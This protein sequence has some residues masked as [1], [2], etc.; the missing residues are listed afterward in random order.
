MKRLESRE[1]DEQAKSR[2]MKLLELDEQAKSREMKLRELEEQAE[3]R[4][5]VGSIAGHILAFAAP[6]ANKMLQSQY[7]G[8]TG[9]G[10]NSPLSSDS[11]L[12]RDRS[13]IPKTKSGIQGSG[14][15]SSKPYLSLEDSIPGYPVANI[16]NN[17]I[18]AR[19]SDHAFRYSV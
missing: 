10:G 18:V 12:V 19:C 16:A 2:E 8:D 4:K 13:L 5:M 15:V 3:F 17:G 11:D 1:L 6:L 7:G 9:C 14:I